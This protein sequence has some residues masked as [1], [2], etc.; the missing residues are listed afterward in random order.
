MAKKEAEKQVVNIQVG[1]LGDR[2]VVMKEEREMARQGT[3]ATWTAHLLTYDSAESERE[4]K[5]P[6][7]LLSG[8]TSVHVSA[9]DQCSDC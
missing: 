6:T 9:T 1:M 7:D 8:R 3:H 5:T 4:E 2:R